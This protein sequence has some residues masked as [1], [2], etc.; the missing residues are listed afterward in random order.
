MGEQVVE[1]RKDPYVGYDPQLVARAAAACQAC[2]A[3]APC[4]LACGHQ[5]DIRS[6]VQLAGTAAC[7]ALALPRWFRSREDVEAAKVTDLI[8]DCYNG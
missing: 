1:I 5:V 4:M 8:C 7:E 3:E 6:I 2:G